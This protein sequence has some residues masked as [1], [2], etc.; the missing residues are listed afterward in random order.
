ME[1]LKHLNKK[2]LIWGGIITAVVLIAALIAGLVFRSRSTKIQAAEMTIQ[3]ATA[4]TGS[5][6]TT[7]VGT[8]SLS[9]GAATDVVVPVGVKVKE[10]LVESGDTVTA[11]QH[12]ATLD[13]A[14]IAS[15]LLEVNASI[16]TVQEEISNLS[17]DTTSNTTEFLEATVLNG[18]LEELLSTQSALSSLLDT[19]VITATCSGTI[20]SINVSADTEITKSAGS[21]DGSSNTVSS[22]SSSSGNSVSK[23][24]ASGSQYNVISLSTVQETSD[25]GD[26]ADTSDGASS[27]TRMDTE[28]VSDTDKEKNSGSETISI[29]NCAINVTAPVSGETPQSE[30]AETDEYT[31]TISFNCSTDTFQAD[32]V[33]TAS[34]QLTA[35]SGYTFSSN[36]LPEV[37]GA[38][39]TAK[40][41]QDDTGNSLLRIKAKFSKTSAEA[42]GNDASENAA[43]QP[44][45]SEDS[46][47]QDGS[48][49]NNGSGS[50]DSGGA[51][52]VLT[53]SGST[54][55]GGSSAGSSSP[56]SDSSAESTS[57]G[58][59]SSDYSPYET[60]AF[61]I[62]SLD[63]AAV[64][65]NVD[66][67]DILSVKVGQTASITLDALEGQEFEGTITSVASTATS[68]NS[69]AKYPVEITLTKT[70]DMKL[71]MSAS[72][73][74]HIDEANDAVLI[75]VNALQEKG[76]ST[77]V[78]T[79]K[80]DNGNLT[81]EV[82][83]ETGL[84]NGSQ[85]AVTS[86][87]KEGDTV[88]YLKA[89]NTESSGKDKTQD[90]M[91]GFGGGMPD[92][93]MPSGDAPS[94]MSPGGG[95]GDRQNKSGQTQ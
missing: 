77:F 53:D 30:I 38:D 3:S 78:Y 64:S 44:E 91:G 13:A 46:K 10:V 18:K 95:G 66:E 40:V 73:T 12:L 17:D 68:G 19:Q 63:Q 11:G 47:T 92:G 86:G 81:D 62:A 71:G 35:R 29:E 21:S 89:D 2:K 24:S 4:E 33:Y 31:G 57:T 56:T 7:V 65:I 83:V 90:M 9:G 50:I 55:A 88:Y 61:S 34:I 67:L 93:E 41:L 6:S 76:S 39:V 15:E 82:E 5:I 48:T 80:D 74:L 79:G 49:N 84:S 14:S 1:K 69:S 28:D 59:S 26:S 36:I 85:V 16:E 60:A 75:P 43:S 37:K 70:S 20:N 32:T 42:K 54:S 25:A 22:G 58:S 23:L 52:S 94:G 51:A 87:L 45:T 72:A 8:G 27:K